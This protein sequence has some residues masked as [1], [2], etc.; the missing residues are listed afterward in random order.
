MP[1]RSGSAKDS[2]AFRARDEELEI[3]ALSS[4]SIRTVRISPRRSARRSP[5]KEFRVLLQRDAC[6]GR[7]DR[8]AS[9]DVSEFIIAC[10][11]IEL[12][13]GENAGADPNRPSWPQFAVKQIKK[14][15]LHL[16]I[17]HPQ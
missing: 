11:S 2:D 4:I 3:S 16:F 12:L 14:R 6:C 7:L 1:K 15:I 10:L 8:V 5:S 13:I 17:A 9:L